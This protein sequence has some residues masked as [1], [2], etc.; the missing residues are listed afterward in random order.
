MFSEELFKLGADLVRAQGTRINP[1]PAV[2]PRPEESL[3]NLQLEI[4]EVG[5]RLAKLQRKHQN[6]TGRR[7]VLP[8]R[9]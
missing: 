9:L 1:F 2:A 4:E 5:S 8:L 6:L 7:Y 3:E